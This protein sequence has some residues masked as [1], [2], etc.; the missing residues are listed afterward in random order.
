MIN[1]QNKSEMEEDRSLTQRARNQ[2]AEHETVASDRPSPLDAP[3]RRRPK[4]KRSKETVDQ[5]T[6]AAIRVMERGGFEAFTVNAIAA[7]A[8]VNVA[9]LYSYF[10]NKHQL[11]ARLA[12]DRME[13]RLGMLRTTFEEAA[14][15]EDWVGAVCQAIERLAALRAGQ[16]GS[17][18]LRRALH[19]SPELWQLDQDGNREAAR[20][21]AELLIKR[22]QPTPGNPELRGRIIAEC[23]TAILDMKAQYPDDLHPEI[24]REMTGLLR[25]QL[26]MP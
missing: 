26:A 2:P 19:A 22:A 17:I 10:A 4:Q 14:Q 7:E 5:I 15:A 13:E 8:G 23:V 3:K 12:M 18:A 11:L 24:D 16:S 20:L 21:V 9:T 25:H 1:L 6:D